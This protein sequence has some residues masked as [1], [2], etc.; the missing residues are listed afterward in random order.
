MAHR[1]PRWPRLHKLSVLASFVALLVFD[2]VVELLVLVGPGMV[3]PVLLVLLVLL[4]VLLVPLVLV[5]V[6]LL[7]LLPGMVAL[8]LLV[9]LVLVPAL[10][11]LMLL[12]LLLLLLPLTT[13]AWGAALPTHA[14]LT[15][16]GNNDIVPLS[17]L[18]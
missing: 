10:L 7:L 15:G 4:V 5:P 18:Q 1:G 2:D 6:R 8:V 17:A 3:A 9:L 13:S 14:S 11:L 16:H 12:L